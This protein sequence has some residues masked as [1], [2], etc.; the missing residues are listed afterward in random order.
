MDFLEDS[1]LTQMKSFD[2]S[3]NKQGQI[4][5]GDLEETGSEDNLLLFLL[6]VLE[7]V[8]C[9]VVISLKNYLLHSTMDQGEEMSDPISSII[10]INKIRGSRDEGMREK[11]M[12][13][14]TIYMN[15]K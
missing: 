4:Y 14:H 7:W 10:D 13:E 12:T 6:E 5:L 3:F 11:N 8:S 15:K 2:S 1:N 9:K